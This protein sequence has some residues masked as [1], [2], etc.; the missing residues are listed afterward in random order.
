MVPRSKHVPQV[1]RDDE[2]FRLIFQLDRIVVRLVLVRGD[3]GSQSLD[4]FRYDF[5]VDLAREGA[6]M[7]LHALAPCVDPVCVHDVIGQAT[8]FFYL[9]A[10]IAPYLLEYPFLVLSPLL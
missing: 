5:V 3:L 1:F 4:L 10:I 2:D 7:V 6:G 9:Q 8:I